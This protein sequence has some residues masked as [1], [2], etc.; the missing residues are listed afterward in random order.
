[1]H[2]E[3]SSGPK[4][5]P[6]PKIVEPVK[7]SELKLMLADLEKNRLD[8]ETAEKCKAKPLTSSFKAISREAYEFAFRNRTDSPK[9]GNYSPRFTVVERR[10]THTLKLVKHTSAPKQR[11]IYVPSCMNPNTAD[12]HS[13]DRNNAVNKVIKRNALTLNEF[14]SKTGEMEQNYRGEVKKTAERLIGPMDFGKQKPREEF[15]RSTDPPHEKRFD[16]VDNASL[17]NSSHRR[18][19][20]LPFTKILSRKNLFEE[21]EVCLSPYD[22]NKECTQK[23]ISTTVLDF[24][25]MSPRKP[26]ILE[27]MVKTP[28][29]LEDLR[30]QAAY[31]QQSNVRG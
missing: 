10:A 24:S 27:H 6:E 4:R 3:F 9:V 28:A 17:V 11:I 22:V 20:S 23:R 26:L 30:L 25:K 16:F 1:M 29:Q 13:R 8:E 19:P 21:R 5:R 7:M 31:V 2:P 18:V 15:V 14:Y 12:F